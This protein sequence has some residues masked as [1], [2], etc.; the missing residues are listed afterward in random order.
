MTVTHPLRVHR[1]YLLIGFLSIGERRT[2]NRERF[3]GIL[4]NVGMVPYAV[5]YTKYLWHHDSALHVR[6][7]TNNGSSGPKTVIITHK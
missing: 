4:G 5:I 7:H 6:P 2:E 3:P 1:G